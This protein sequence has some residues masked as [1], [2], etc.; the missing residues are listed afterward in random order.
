MVPQHATANRPIS[1][2]G[3]NG[4]K[5]PAFEVS[6]IIKLHQRLS[7]AS[8]VVP[9]KD[10]CWSGWFPAAPRSCT[11]VAAG[12]GPMVQRGGGHVEKQL[13]IIGWIMNTSPLWIWIWSYSWRYERMWSSLVA[14]TP[15]FDWEEFS[16]WDCNPVDSSLERGRNFNFVPPPSGSLQWF[17]R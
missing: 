12:P 9:P 7:D 1:Q 13:Q 17:M 6:S 11:S 14:H 4:N 5:N 16:T 3:W 8:P 10:F 15:G 2:H